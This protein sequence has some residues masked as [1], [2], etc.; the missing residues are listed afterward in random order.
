MKRRCVVPSIQVRDLPEQIYNK[1]KNNAQKDHRSLSQQAIVTL[2]K[3][4]GIDENHK[5]R[6][7]IL[8][9]QIMSRR[10]TFDIA[11]LENPV[12]L[13]REDRDR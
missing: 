8:V 13:I 9:D 11:K 12:N 1:I 6:R 5:E 2:K 7:R 10:V 4:L 3:G